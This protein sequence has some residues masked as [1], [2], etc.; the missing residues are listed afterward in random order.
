MFTLTYLSPLRRF[1]VSALVLKAFFYPVIFV[2]CN[3]RY[4]IRKIAG[5]CIE[6]FIAQKPIETGEFGS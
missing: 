5:L 4:S 2:G 1:A 3:V 6:V